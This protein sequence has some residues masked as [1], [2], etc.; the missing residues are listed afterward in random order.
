MT[1]YENVTQKSGNPEEILDV[2]SE[3]FFYQTKLLAIIFYIS[4]QINKLTSI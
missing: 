4:A 3:N 1:K 2:D